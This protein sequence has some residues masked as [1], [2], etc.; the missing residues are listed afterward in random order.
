[1]IGHIL[2]AGQRLYTF[3]VY[4]YMLYM[5]IV[6]GIIGNKLLVTRLVRTLW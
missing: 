4:M 6:L 1:M 2:W 3:T 5:V